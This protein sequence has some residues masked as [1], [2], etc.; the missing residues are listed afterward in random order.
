[1]FVVVCL[2]VLD[3]SLA[4]WGFATRT[5]GL[6]ECYEPLRGLGVGLGSC[7]AGLGPPVALCCWS[8]RGDASVVVLFVLCLRVF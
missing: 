1:M 7:G 6:T 2:F 3:D 5:E 4:G 8:F